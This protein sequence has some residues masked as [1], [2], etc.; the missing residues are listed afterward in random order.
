M[1]RRHI[2]YWQ[3]RVLRQVAD[4]WTLP[5]QRASSW[6]TAL[7]RL[8][9]RG[10]VRSKPDMECGRRK[11]WSLTKQGEEELLNARAEYESPL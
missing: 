7:R 2:S 1:A 9:A 10:S 6:Y 5:R 8:V 11:V 3:F 4:G